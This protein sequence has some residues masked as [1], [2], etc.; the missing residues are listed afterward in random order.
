MG[1]EKT[2]KHKEFWRDTPWCVSCLSRGNVSSVL[3]HVPSVPRT[4]CPLNWNFHI[5]RPKRPGCPWDVPKLSLGRF[6]GI[7]TTKFLD[8]KIFI[9]FSLSISSNTVQPSPGHIRCRTKGK[10]LQT[11]PRLFRVFWHLFPVSSRHLQIPT[12]V[13]CKILRI[14]EK[15]G[16]V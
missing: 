16:W 5:N 11:Y 1:K 8:V 13:Q 15:G 10:S 12:I 9:G 7:P 3:S 4:F 2:N 6:R 14:T